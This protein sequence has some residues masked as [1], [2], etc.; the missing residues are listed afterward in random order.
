MVLASVLRVRKS[1]TVPRGAVTRAYSS[2]PRPYRFH[3]SASWEGKPQEPRPRVRARPF[4]PDSEIG[5][6][7]DATLAR[8]KVPAGN[9]IGEDFFFVQEMRNHSGLC[10][11]VADGVGGWVDSGVDPSLFSQALMYHSHRYAQ[12]AWV[13]EPEI[14]PTQE[15]EEREQ[16]EGWELH[17]SECLK[18]AY[19]G[20]LRERAVAAGSSTA[21]LVT[22]NSSS[23]LLRAANLGDS[24]FSVLRSS[25]V[26]HHQ[27]PQT[28]YFN[29]PKQLSKAPASLS[30][31][32]IVDSPQDADLFETQLRDGDLVIAY[33]DGLTDN[34]FPEEIAWI[35]AVVARQHAALPPLQ[36]QSNSNEPMAE[37]NTED[38]MVQM[39]A[40]HLV[41]YAQKAMSM[42][43]RVSPFER[44]AA[45]EGLHWRGGK[46]DDVTVVVALVKET[47]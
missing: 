24:G 31:G 6:W 44:A 23:G 17:P 28:H 27:T 35:C 34:V 1:S 20:V 10:F 30:R 19:D 33:T 4:A 7:R 32:T 45:L 5:R 15:Y 13:G 29:C 16:V 43:N 36:T 9:H 12:N 11:G 14:D 22:L 41:E 39:M 46:V 42:K 26:F 37:Q 18:L 38:Q 21:C 47:P 8:H 25:K 2:L 3:V 40:H